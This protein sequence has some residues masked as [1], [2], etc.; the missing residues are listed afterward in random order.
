MN[1]IL[2]ADWLAIL[3]NEI[4]EIYSII[5][6]GKGRNAEHQFQYTNVKEIG[7]MF[8]NLHYLEAR[9][10][11]IYSVTS[12]QGVKEKPELLAGITEGRCVS[13]CSDD[14]YAYIAQQ[15]NLYVW[16]K[17]DVS[18][19]GVAKLLYRHERPIIK[20]RR[21]GSG[22]LAIQAGDGIFWFNIREAR[23]AVKKKANVKLYH[24]K[25]DN[26][27]N[28]WG[29]YNGVCYQQNNEDDI[30]ILSSNNHK[31]FSREEFQS[32]KNFS[33]N[34]MTEFIINSLGKLE[35]RQRKGVKDPSWKR[36]TSK[37]VD[38]SINVAMLNLVYVFADQRTVLVDRL[39]TLYE[40]VEDEQK[41]FGC[42]Q[43]FN[44]TLKNLRESL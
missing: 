44:L 3:N 29:A 43:I 34:D 21:L 15:N 20:V 37:N 9:S 24:A 33:S 16:N 22:M 35:V 30:R 12:W 18:K 38:R 27:T 14:S 32:A 13:F 26:I 6:K 39:G 28:F 42:Y 40:L 7:A 36:C 4:L 1:I 2:G 23:E 8:S 41:Q 31:G 5:D 10:G 11:K 25:I 17:F 19:N